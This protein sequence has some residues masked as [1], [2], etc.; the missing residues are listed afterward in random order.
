MDPSTGRCSAVYAGTVESPWGIGLKAVRGARA[1][2]AAYRAWRAGRIASKAIEATAFVRGELFEA[3]IKSKAG[4]IGVLAE[5]EMAG[6]RLI[7]KDTVIYGRS[8]DLVNE[9]G[10]AAFRNA[11]RAVS[12]RAAAAGFTELRIIG[13]RAPRSSSA[14]PGRTFDKVF[15]LGGKP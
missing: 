8:G 14:N 2:V 7:L 5:V 6:D 12:Q 15:K 11:V 4:K 13:T 9:V 1:A 10:I 3:T